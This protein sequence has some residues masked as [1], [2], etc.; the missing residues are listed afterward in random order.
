MQDEIRRRV[1]ETVSAHRNWPCRKGCDECCRRLAS[2]PRVSREEWK[3]IA[4]A[5]E[6]LPRATAESARQRIRDSGRWPA[7]SVC[8]LLDSNSGTCLVYEARPLACRA[9]GFYAERGDVLGCS[10]IESISREAPDVIWGNH[11]ALEQ[12]MRQQGAAAGLPVWLAREESG[13]GTA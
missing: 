4:D 9:Y 2:L 10:R 3:Q 8:P 6:A 1:E 5:L 7:T 12:D 13:T 11:A